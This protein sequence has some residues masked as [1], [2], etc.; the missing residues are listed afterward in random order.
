MENV[1][2]KVCG[3]GDRMPCPRC[4]E[5]RHRHKQVVGVVGAHGSF[6]IIYGLLVK[7]EVA[8]S[9]GKLIFEEQM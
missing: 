5:L 8:E 1:L 7:K 9:R 2:E 6:P 4:Q 3:G